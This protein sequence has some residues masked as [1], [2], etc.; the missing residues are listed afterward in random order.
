[1]TSSQNKALHILSIDEEFQNLIRPLFKNEYMQLEA[2][3]I[4]DGCREPISIWNGVIVDGH[5]RYKICTEHQIPFAVEEM[6]FTCREE[7]ISWI[8]TNQLGRRNLTEESRKYLI[9]K[10]YESERFLNRRRA[11]YLAVGKNEADNGL[12]Y[13]TF[14]PEQSFRSGDTRR[15]TAERIAMD[16]HIS[17]GTVEKYYIYARAIDE[18]EKKSPQMA[19]KILSGRYKVSH[20]GVL[21]LARGSSEEIQDLNK[22]LEHTKYPFAKYQT[23]RQEIQGIARV[24]K[25]SIDNRPSIKDMPEY[26]PDAEVIGLTLTIPSWSSSINRII[27]SNLETVSDSAKQKLY[28][29]LIDLQESVSLMLSA[30]E[31]DN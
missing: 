2:N 5:N 17:H 29:A 4:A 26:D 12:P 14:D 15:K 7:A 25:G 6:S 13:E 24:Q 3:L 21:S 28:T 9:G 20:E 10:Q 18:I 30:I 22:R 11:V 8:C 23:T 19:Q 16:N 1:M 27:Q 31:E